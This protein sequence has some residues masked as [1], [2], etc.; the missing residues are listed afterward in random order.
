MFPLHTSVEAG[1]VHVIIYCDDETKK[2][3]PVWSNQGSNPSPGSLQAIAARIGA[4]IRG[5]RLLACSY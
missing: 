4:I 5:T 3:Q 1:K 2:N